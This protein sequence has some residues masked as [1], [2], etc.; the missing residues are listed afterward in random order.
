M[1]LPGPENEPIS[2]E[3]PEAVLASQAKSRPR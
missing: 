3:T 1:K 2:D